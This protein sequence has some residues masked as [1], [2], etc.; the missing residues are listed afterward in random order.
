VSSALLIVAGLAWLLI[1]ADLLV[2]GGTALASRLGVRPI[3][4][5]LT[6]VALGTSLPEL[7]VGIDSVRQGSRVW[8]PAT[9]TLTSTVRGDRDIA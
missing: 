5:G 3:V 2:R 7:A 9:S 4:I 8:L 6:V 1:G